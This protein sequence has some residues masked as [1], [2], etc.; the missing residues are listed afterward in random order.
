M[1]SYRYLRQIEPDEPQAPARERTRRE[2]WSNWWHY[3]WKQ[4]VAAAALLAGLG[5]LA[6]AALLRP[7]TDYQIALVTAGTLTSEET[8]T[9]KD[10]V[11]AV[12]P[13]RNGDGQV[14]ITVNDIQL[15][16]RTEST[17]GAVMQAMASNIDKLHADLYNCQ[18][19][20]FIMDD[21]EQFQANMEALGLPQD[22]SP[23]PDADWQELVVPFRQSPALSSIESLGQS[24]EGLYLGRRAS[25]TEADARALE[26]SDA[27][28]EALFAA[29]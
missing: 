8:Q 27:L 13:D 23:A 18:S 28:W 9:L 26:G 29:Q 12:A 21:P 1:A 17:D 15:D 16:F 11:A 5:W 14:L 2:K 4:L 19:C 3:H 6:S 25:L 20:I 10:A 7:E 22:G 24:T